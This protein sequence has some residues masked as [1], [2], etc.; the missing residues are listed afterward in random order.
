MYIFLALIPSSSVDI[1]KPSR[2]S[3]LLRSTYIWTREHRCEVTPSSSPPPPSPLPTSSPH[4]ALPLVKWHLI[5]SRAYVANVR[6]LYL[7]LHSS[8]RRLCKHNKHDGAIK[9]NHFPCYWP[10]VKG[11]LW[12]PVNS[13]H[14]RLWRGAVMFSLI[15]AWTNEWANHKDAGDLRRHRAH[16]D[17]TVMNS[18]YRLSLYNRLRGEKCHILL[19]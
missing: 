5:L 16:H 9:W 7:L 13:P 14:K 12:S 11:N 3:S 8:V 17:V 4:P 19:I 18:I 2:S 1:S 10:F 15:C 6:S